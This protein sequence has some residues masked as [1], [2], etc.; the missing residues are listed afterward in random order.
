MKNNQSGFSL[1]ELLLVV[2]I[3]GII[4]AIAVPSLIKAR[5]SAENGSAFSAMRTFSTLQVGYSLNHNRF[6]RLDEILADQQVRFGTYSGT[7][8]SKGRFNFQMSPAAPTDEDL[9]LEYK[10][11]ASRANSGSETPYVLEITQAGT[12]KQITP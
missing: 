10:I 2:V 12:I 8:L 9:K 7:T 11:I 5:E 1:I 4:A 3:I 6:G